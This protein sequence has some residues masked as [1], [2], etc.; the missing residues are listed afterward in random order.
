ML[1]ERGGA[2]VRIVTGVPLSLKGDPVV[3]SR[4][5]VG[6]SDSVIVLRTRA[7]GLPSA[8]ATVAIGAQGT[9]TALSSFAHSSRPRL[10]GE[11][12]RPAQADDL[13]AV[14]NWPHTRAEDLDLAVVT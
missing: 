9:P 7:S 14:L 13:A 3:R 5:M 12:V 2:A 4:P 8:W 11:A 1:T 10:S 6:W